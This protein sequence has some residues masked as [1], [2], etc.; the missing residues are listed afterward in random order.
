MPA[1]AGTWRTGIDQFDRFSVV[2]WW[3]NIK[4]LAGTRDAGLARGTS[5]QPIVPD[6]VEAPGQNVSQEP[7]YKF[8][9]GKRHDALAFG[10]VSAIVLV[11]QGDALPV[12]RE[13]SP[14]RDSDTVRIAR[15][16]GK[17]RFRTSERR[18]GV[19]YP[20][21]LANGRYMA[22]ERAGVGKR[23]QMTEEGEPAALMQRHQPGQEQPPEQ[24]TQD[25]HGQQER[26]TR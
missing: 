17:H 16:I 3:C 8:R 18:L 7:A 23:C 1:A 2:R 25:T 9:R 11:A 24:C 4:Q 13:Q 20:A 22:P 5:E 14:V 21:L 15:Q 26:R 6:A 12:E 10:A 19:N